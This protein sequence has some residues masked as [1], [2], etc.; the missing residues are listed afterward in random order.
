MLIAI[1]FD[2][3]A[4]DGGKYASLIEFSSKTLL[5]LG[6]AFLGFGDDASGRLD[7]FGKGNSGMIGVSQMLLHRQLKTLHLPRFQA[8][9]A[10]RTQIFVVEGKAL[11]RFDAVPLM[12]SA[13]SKEMDYGTE[14]DG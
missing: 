9:Y 4:E 8:E 2:F 13:A 7:A 14:A 11:S 12:A 5:R 1:A 3:L 6:V 10:Q